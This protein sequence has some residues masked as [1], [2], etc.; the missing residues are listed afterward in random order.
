[1]R[2]RK[3]WRARYLS[4]HRAGRLLAEGGMVVERKGGWHVCR[5][6]DARLAPAGRISSAMA[7]RLISEGIVVADSGAPG[8]WVARAPAGTPV[9]LAPP[10]HFFPVRIPAIAGQRPAVPLLH[11]LLSD[12]AY[13]L[14]IRARLRAAANRFAADSEQAASSQPVTMRWDGVPAGGV[15]RTGLEGGPGWRA[16]SAA[17]RLRR[18]E[19]LLGGPAMRSLERLILDDARRRAFADHAG[20]PVAQAGTAAFAALC[21]LADAYDGSFRA[22]PG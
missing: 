16:R 15:G 20:L 18:L 7:A 19:A 4:E 9:G 17:A 11:A 22:P 5:S 2:G 8:R 12:S 14:D 21:A 1:M 6:R 3:R 10:A 13:S